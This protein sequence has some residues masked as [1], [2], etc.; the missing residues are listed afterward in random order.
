M[1]A[2]AGRTLLVAGLTA[3]VAA[4]GGGTSGGSVAAS[5]DS[6][7]GAVRGFISAVSNNDLKGAE[8]WVAPDERPAFDGLLKGTSGFSVTFKVAS[9]DIAGE[10][11]DPG[12]PNKAQVRFS[13]SLQYC[14]SGSVA[15]QV[16]NNCS[17]FGGSTTSNSV[18]CVRVQGQWYVSAGGTS[19]GAGTT[20]TN[21]TSTGTDSGAGGTDTT[22]TTTDTTGSS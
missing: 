4:C 3:V 1:R 22:D 20:D 21:A 19:T 11:V 2:A 15:G 9:F 17:A 16:V 8:D 10:T 5:H 14:I 7:S 6:P 18:D 13:G 12:D